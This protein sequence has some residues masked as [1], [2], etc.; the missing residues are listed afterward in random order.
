LQADGNK[1]EHENNG[2]INKSS[3]VHETNTTCDKTE[4][5]P[6]RKMN[7]GHGGVGIHF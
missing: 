4:N 6:A 2:Q 7:R 5:L 1:V 3:M